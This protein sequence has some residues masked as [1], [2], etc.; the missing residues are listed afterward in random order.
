MMIIYIFC[1][2]VLYRVM[3]LISYRC[4]ISYLISFPQYFFNLPLSLLIPVL[5]DLSYLL[6]EVSLHPFFACPDQSNDLNLAPPSPS[7]PWRSFS[8]C[9]E[10][11]H[12][13]SYLLLCH[14]IHLNIPFSV[15]FIF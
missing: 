12:L 13:E 8:L 9:P 10:Y 5:T 7:P 3:F 1:H 11:L 6:I 15:T 14:T 4:I 2:Y